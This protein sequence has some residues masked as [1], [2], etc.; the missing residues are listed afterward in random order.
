M[1][2]IERVGDLQAKVQHLLGREPP[3]G[4]PVFQGPPLQTLHDDER[5][6]LVLADVV[7]GADVRMIQGRGRL[8]LTLEALAGC[9]VFEVGLGKELQGHMAVK[10][11]VLGLVD[12]AHAP[13]AQFLDDAVVGDDLPD[14]GEW[15]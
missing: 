4:D 10:A 6:A 14:H 15:P 5:P 3:G 9:R 7:D 13:A 11:C 8:R 2:G 12:D 1:R